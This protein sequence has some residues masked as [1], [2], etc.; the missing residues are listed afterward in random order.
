MKGS[1]FVNIDYAF[2]RQGRKWQLEVLLTASLILPLCV[3]NSGE[4]LPWYEMSTA[5]TR[6]PADLMKMFCATYGNAI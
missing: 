3:L 1:V 4:N 5:E 2:C 6:I